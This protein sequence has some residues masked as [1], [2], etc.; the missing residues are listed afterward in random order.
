MTGFCSISLWI[1][2][3]AGLSDTVQNS[4]WA[5]LKLV[6]IARFMLPDRPASSNRALFGGGCLQSEGMQLAAHSAPQRGIDDLM[7]LDAGKTAEPLGNHGG[8]IVVT[9][10]NQIFHGD[11]RV[12]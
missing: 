9:V 5:P 11:M 6:F 1:R 12:R 2:V 8:G 3:K 4:C 10:P 7:L